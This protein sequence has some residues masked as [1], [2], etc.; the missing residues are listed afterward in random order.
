LSRVG[1]TLQ[2]NYSRRGQQ[3]RVSGR[4]RAFLRPTPALTSPCLP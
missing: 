3:C 4:I 2:R 1:I